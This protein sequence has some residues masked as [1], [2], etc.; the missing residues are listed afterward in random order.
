[1]SLRSATIKSVKTDHRHISRIVSWLYINAFAAVVVFKC[2]VISRQGGRSTRCD[3]TTIGFTEN[4]PPTSISV[5]SV[6]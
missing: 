3:S 1:M 6:Q 4:K 2:V 5:L